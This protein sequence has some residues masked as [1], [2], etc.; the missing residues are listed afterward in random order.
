MDI[1][2]RFEQNPL[3]GPKDIKPSMPGME[4]ECLLNPGVFQY[5]DKTWLLLRVA[6][7]PRQEAGKISFPVYNKEGKIEILSFDEND[8]ALDASDPRV[9][10]YNGEYYLTTLSHL[11]LICSDDHINFTEPEGT[12]PIMG[13]GPQ[14]TFGIEDCRVSTMEDGYHLT[15]TKVSA[16]AVGVGYIHTQDWKTFDRRGMIFPPHNKDCA[17]F[18]EKINGKY[19][20]LHRPSSPEL[21]GNYI[22]IAESPDRIHWGNHKLLA[23]TRA[24]KWDSARVGAGA[25]PIKTEKGWLEIYHGA[26]KENRYCLGALLLDL[27]DPSKVIA[28]S[29]API[30]EPIMDYEKTGFFGNVVFTNGHLV[31]GDTITIYYGASDE[32][33]CGARFSIN[34]ILSSLNS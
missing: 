23:T 4:I 10:I 22:W 8:P 6:E 21:G 11:R 20:A 18:E 33:I 34:E 7:R 26:T 2:K 19:Y 9:V 29:E 14:E 27:K 30:M 1:A 5:K 17:I 32:V 28:R 24:G 13:E 16:H 3:L 25:A 31:N 12:L 15:Y